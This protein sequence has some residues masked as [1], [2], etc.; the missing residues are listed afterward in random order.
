MSELQLHDKDVFKDHNENVIPHTLLE[1]SE[2][3]DA[4]LFVPRDATVLE[5]G[6]RY[7]TVSCI[8]NRM[9]KNP[10]AHVAVEPDTVVIP[11]L[12]KNRE[13]AGASFHIWAGAVSKKPL[14]MDCSDYGGATR[15]VES[16]GNVKTISIEELEKLHGLRFDT[17]VADCEG[18]FGQFVEENDMSKYRIILIEKDAPWICDYNKI[19]ET[20]VDSGFIMIKNEFNQ[21]DRSVYVN[22]S[23]LGFKILQQSVGHGHLGLFGRIGYPTQ[24]G[25]DVPVPEG[26][27][28]I[29]AHGHS[30][31]VL[32]ATKE[33]KLKGGLLPSAQKPPAILFICDGVT[34][35]T[36]TRANEITN[37]IV[38]TPGKHTLS[39]ST[40]CWAHSVW[41][42][43]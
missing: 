4:Y 23:H 6:A 25:T 14:Q 38:L 36:L 29:S 21:V 13:R 22:T 30:E 37:T 17:I 43:Q 33:L 11:A 40:G 41:Y 24:L 26:W 2:Q 9:L 5:L 12:E 15:I 32:E 35:G 18:F 20:L 3:L 27:T 31:I 16:S 34:V 39:I 1:R 10:K 7:G 28:S 42:I 8:I 19:H